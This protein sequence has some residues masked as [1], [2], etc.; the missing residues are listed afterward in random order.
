MNVW[1]S[2]QKDRLL[3]ERGEH[4]EPSQ[5]LL[6]PADVS[7]ALLARPTKAEVQRGL[8]KFARDWDLPSCY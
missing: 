7:A 5:L 3:L 2:Q 1:Q 8:W 6:G 4:L